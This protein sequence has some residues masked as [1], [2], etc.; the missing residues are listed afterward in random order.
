MAGRAKI[1]QNPIPMTARWY[2][3]KTKPRQ[4]NVALLNLARQQFEAYLPYVTVERLRGRLRLGKRITIEREP[5][6]PGYVLVRF[7]FSPT[8]WRAV[9]ATRGVGSLLVFGDSA[10]PIPLPT[11]EVESIQR[12]EL[13]G[14]LFI[15]E[16]QHI[17]KGDNVR[18]KFG[19]AAEAIGS[20]I[21]T[22]GERIELLLNLLGR[23]TRVRVPLHAVE[24]MDAHRQMRSPRLVR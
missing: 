4:E 20:V 8:N 12:R 9:N 10:A 24:V 3:A 21:F 19:S 11:N 14:K 16:V 17:R 23:Q 15:S 13:S 18:I 7:A 2:A 1:E 5:L 22:R 6:F